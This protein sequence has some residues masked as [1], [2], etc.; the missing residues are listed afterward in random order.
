V[1][2]HGE[3]CKIYDHKSAASA[4][5]MKTPDDLRLDPQ[6]II[7]AAYG[8]GLGASTV[9]LQW[10]NGDKSSLRE[11]SAGPAAVPVELS[12]TRAECDKLMHDVDTA[13][14]MILLTR[15]FYGLQQGNQV[16]KDPQA[17]GAVGRKC[18][19]VSGCLLHKPTVPLFE[20]L[21]QLRKGE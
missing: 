20:K 18:W 7:Y 5:W 6:A 14:T 19:N 1:R 15:L 12:I 17:C 9:D 21:T 4:Q 16:R 13:A 2:E 11:G 10:T 3:P 8:Y